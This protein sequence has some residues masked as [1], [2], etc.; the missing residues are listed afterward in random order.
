VWLFI[1]IFSNI[2]L[3]FYFCPVYQNIQVLELLFIA[4]TALCRANFNFVILVLSFEVMST[5]CS[6][7]VI[8]TRK[9]TTSLAKTKYFWFHSSKFRLGFCVG[10]TCIATSAIGRA[11]AQAVSRWLPT[12]AARVRSRVWSSGICGGQ[13]FSPS[14]S[15]SPANLHSTNCS[16]ITLTYHLGLVQ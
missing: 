4:C 2:Y 1:I 13:K 5:V 10:N 3:S 7:T 12:T 6:L 14:T 9:T 11:I 8:L 15:V 16:T